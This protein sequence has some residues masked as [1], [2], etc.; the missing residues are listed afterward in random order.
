MSNIILYV[1]NCL[2]NLL[3]NGYML[4]NDDLIVLQ[5]V[6]V[7]VVGIGCDLIIHEDDNVQPFVSD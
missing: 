5:N 1:R 6:S 2:E 4:C 7:A 3:P